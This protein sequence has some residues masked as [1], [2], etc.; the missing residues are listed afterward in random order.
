VAVIDAESAIH[1]DATWKL[2]ADRTPTALLEKNR[3]KL[4]N[5]D[6]VL[7]LVMKLP[8]VS[9]A[10]RFS[11]VCTRLRSVPLSE[12]ACPELATVLAPLSNPIEPLPVH[13][14]V[15]CGLYLAADDTRRPLGFARR[16]QRIPPCV[17]AATLRPH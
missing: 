10:F 1:A 7:L 11:V 9:D 13:A 14:K 2:P 17:S 12:V 5:R 15:T 4:L 16:A 6:A 8:L 3:I